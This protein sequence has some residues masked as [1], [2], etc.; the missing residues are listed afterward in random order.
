MTVHT[1]LAKYYAWDRDMSEQEIMDQIKSGKLDGIEM[2]GE[3]YVRYKTASPTP[4]ASN[5]TYT[6]YSHPTLGYEAVKTGFTWPGFFLTWI[7]AFYKKLWVIGGVLMVVSLFISLA[8]PA[9]SG[10]QLGAGEA[11]VW[12]LIMLAPMTYTGSNGNEWLMNNLKARGFSEV[13]AVEATTPDGALASLRGSDTNHSIQ[14]TTS[15]DTKECPKCA[16]TIKAK[17]IICRFCGHE[18]DKQ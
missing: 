1:Q 18:F 8:M 6:V 7:W 14:V 17:A 16:E 11:V 15:P 3:W 5:N 13:K 12:L 2:D 4:N 9:I 10:S